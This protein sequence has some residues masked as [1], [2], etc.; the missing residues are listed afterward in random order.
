MAERKRRLVERIV[1]PDYLEGLADKSLAELRALRDECREGETELSFERRLSQARIDILTA[2][3]ERR[4]GGGGDDDLL[5][6]LPEILATEERVG[7]E[8]SLPARAPDFSIPRNADVPRR[9]V[10]EIVGEQTLTRL[11]GMA[12]EELRAIVAA[13][14]E[15]EREVSQRR[16]LVH[17]V[18]DAIQS[19][20]VRR[21]ASGE[22]DPAALLR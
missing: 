1:E 3:L 16:K 2:E 11:P 14:A 18:M 8:A 10:E 19:E 22:A 15:H 9:R 6:R 7:S 4:A 21:Y 5:S 17:E 13:L 12:T 20:I